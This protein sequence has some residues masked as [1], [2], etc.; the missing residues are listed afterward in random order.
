MTNDNIIQYLR[1]HNAVDDDVKDICIALLHKEE[2]RSP[3][4]PT[5]MLGDI[6][7][8]EKH[9]RCPECGKAVIIKADRCHR[10]GQALKWSEKNE[11]KRN[12]Y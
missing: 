1:G 8:V 7:A 10:C 2:P 9:F 6:V 11:N 3:L 4:Y 12:H 5:R